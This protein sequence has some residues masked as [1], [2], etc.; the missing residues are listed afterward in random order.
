MHESI[1]E[2]SEARE[3]LRRVTVPSGAR[4]RVLL[5]L[6]SRTRERRKWT[7]RLGVAGAGMLVGAAAAA[8]GFGL[9]ARPGEPSPPTR[10]APAAA[11]AERAPSRRA[12]PEVVP[13][14]PPVASAEDREHPRAIVNPPAASNRSSE[15]VEPSELSQ[16]VRAYQAAV[17]LIP[18][19]PAQA[20][21]ALRAFRARWPG[22]ALGQEADLRIVQTLMAL[23]QAEDAR[24]AARTFVA[25]YPESP[26]A[27]DMRVVAGMTTEQ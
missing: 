2:L 11:Q 7:V 20:L 26:R 13:P 10:P 3:L 22:S 4:E 9:A 24:Q 14:A 5:G 19:N 18:A 8:L 21:A 27:P 17:E 23:G 1:P 25:R 15:G 6:R 16:Q 12:L